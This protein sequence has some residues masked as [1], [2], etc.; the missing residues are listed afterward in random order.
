MTWGRKGTIVLSVVAASL[1]LGAAT[2]SQRYP[3]PNPY[4][5]IQPH[6]T[7]TNT[8]THTHTQTR[9]LFIESAKPPSSRGYA[10]PKLNQLAR[11]FSPL[12]KYDRK[13]S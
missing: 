11:M 6:N 10:N 1:T 7:H 5:K 4:L 12:L 8:H 3:P 2:Q 9:D 13:K